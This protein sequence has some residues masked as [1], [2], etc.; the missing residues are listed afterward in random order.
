MTKKKKNKLPIKYHP[1]FNY[2][3]L[4]PEKWN[5]E[6]VQII[7]IEYTPINKKET[8]VSK[9][10]KKSEGL[11]DYSPIYHQLYMTSP[12]G[13]I[14]TEPWTEKYKKIFEEKSKLLDKVKY[15]KTSHSVLLKKFKNSVS[16]LYILNHLIKNNNFNLFNTLVHKLD[17]LEFDNLKY[18]LWKHLLTPNSEKFIQEI[19]MMHIRNIVNTKETKFVEIVA[20]ILITIP[21]PFNIFKILV[22]PVIIPL[23]NPHIFIKQIHL[24]LKDAKN[25]VDLIKRNIRRIIIRLPSFSEYSAWTKELLKKY[26][27]KEKDQHVYVDFL[28]NTLEP[29]CDNLENIISGDRYSLTPLMVEVISNYLGYFDVKCL[30]IFSVSEKEEDLKIL[31]K[32]RETL[33]VKDFNFEN[34]SSGKTSVMQ[35]LLKQY[36]GEKHSNA[37]VVTDTETDPDPK[38]SSFLLYLRN[39]FPDLC[40]QYFK[41]AKDKYTSIMDQLKQYFPRELINI[42]M[43]YTFPDHVWKITSENLRDSANKITIR[44]RLSGKTKFVI[45]QTR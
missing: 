16:Q 45:C 18:L 29:S 24:Q 1:Q 25:P 14:K 28:L 23:L 17:N 19:V 36:I 6:H 27:F 33:P 2:D 7:P 37:L 43:E 5:T 30:Y 38:I 34:T 12:L 32:L 11:I 3:L 10:S 9:E 40:Q 20:Y 42:M 8:D 41:M 44:E 22:N 13:N 4:D 15:T 21:L 26:I 39:Q 31:L 35:Q